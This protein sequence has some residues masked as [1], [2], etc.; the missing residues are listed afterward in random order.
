MT[1]L[2]LTWIVTMTHKHQY[3]HHNVLYTLDLLCMTSA[4]GL[5]GFCLYIAPYLLFD[6]QA[7]D[8]PVF[9]IQIAQWYR[10]NQGLTD[11][12]LILTVFLPFVLGSVA[13]MCISRLIS[14]FIEPPE[15]LMGTVQE[16][17]RPNSAEN[18]IKRY[19]P[20]IVTVG[21]MLLVFIVL[22]STEIFLLYDVF[23]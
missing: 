3:E 21:L 12:M 15:V 6:Y 17:V 5:L 23:R 10:T 13:F 11:F 16:E 19:F 7:Y 9:V 1:N 22:I 2:S 8:V 4:V 20:L 18:K 14:F